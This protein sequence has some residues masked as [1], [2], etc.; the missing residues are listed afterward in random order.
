MTNTK[1]EAK[2]SET[3]EKPASNKQENDALPNTEKN[4]RMNTSR[5][6]SMWGNQNP[7]C[8]INSET[9]HIEHPE[10]PRIVRHSTVISLVGAGLADGMQS[11]MADAACGSTWL[12]SVG[13]QQSGPPS[14]VDCGGP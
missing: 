14:G 4:D 12:P 11:R 6:R 9:R 7:K 5:N 2:P 1:D 8:D 13:A 10:L 3:P